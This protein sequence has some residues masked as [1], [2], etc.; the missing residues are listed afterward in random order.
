MRFRGKY[1]DLINWEVVGCGHREPA[2]MAQVYWDCLYSGCR[3]VDGK[4]VY[5]PCED[6]LEPDDD[7]A[8]IAL[9]SRKV[10]L[11]G[12]MEEMTPI[13]TGVVRSFDPGP[14]NYTKT[15]GALEML[16]TPALC[17]PVGVLPHRFWRRGALS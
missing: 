14:G 15:A 9:G 3:R 2:D 16:E 5:T 8:V 7:I 11:N 12:R 13:E 6:A 17:A 1:A 4:L 10:Y